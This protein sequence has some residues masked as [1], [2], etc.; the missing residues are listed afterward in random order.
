VVKGEGDRENQV[1]VEAKTA[2]KPENE[3]EM[4]QEIKP[5]K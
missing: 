2:I 3:P 5:F 1:R 4:K